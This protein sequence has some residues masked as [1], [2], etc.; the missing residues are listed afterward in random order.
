MEQPMSYE[1]SKELFKEITSNEGTIHEYNRECII[2]G[3]V[4]QC[5]SINDFFF[6]CKEWLDIKYNDDVVIYKNEVLF[7]CDLYAEAGI[8]CVE[9]FEKDSIQ[10]SLFDACQWI[11]DNKDK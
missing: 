10:Q 3:D 9:S 11:L 7:I 4:E 6:M 1:I 8:F 5:I 2:N